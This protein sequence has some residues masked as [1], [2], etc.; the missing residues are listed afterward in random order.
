MTEAHGGGWIPFPLGRLNVG[1]SLPCPLYRRRDGEPL[2]RWHEAGEPIA[3]DTLARIGDSL[4][5]IESSSL[6][7]FAGFLTS[8][9]ERALDEPGGCSTAIGT[10]IHDAGWAVLSDYFNRPEVVECRAKVRRVARAMAAARHREG[11]LDTL[12]KSPGSTDAAVH[13]TRVAALSLLIGRAR[14]LGDDASRRLAE[15]ALLHDVGEVVMAPRNTEPCESTWNQAAQV[16]HPSVGL[17]L[18]RAHGNV[19]PMIADCVLSHHERLHGRGVPYGL[20]GATL[21]LAA[22]IVGLADALDEQHAKNPDESLTES[23]AKR[24]ESE[25]EGFDPL[26]VEALLDVLKG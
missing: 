26:L 15:G 17:G 19:D 25:P 10:Q 18:L 3:A 23:L 24:V 11:L 7:G 2:D 14:G 8:R 21:S 13:G 1:E 22:R 16:Q 20:T 9:M 4:V 6:G 5:F 12:L